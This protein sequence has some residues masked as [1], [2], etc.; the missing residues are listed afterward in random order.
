VKERG[1]L[2]GHGRVLPMTDVLRDVCSL[3]SLSCPIVSSRPPS[4]HNHILHLIL[5]VRQCCSGCM[6]CYQMI[7]TRR[8]QP[9][10]NILQLNPVYV[11]LGVTDTRLLCELIA[12]VAVLLPQVLDTT[13]DFL[14]PQLAGLDT[15]S[16]TFTGD[17]E[18]HDF[19]VHGAKLLTATEEHAEVILALVHPSSLCG[20]A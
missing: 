11:Q 16:F 17:C 13:L 10:R 1:F 2:R 8:P 6:Q 3:R 18:S 20:T 14:Q 15:L 4:L 19:K 9:G 5:A 7:V 12:H